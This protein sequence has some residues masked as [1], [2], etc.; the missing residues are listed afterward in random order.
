MKIQRFAMLAVLASSVIALATPA[1]AADSKAAPA[2]LEYNAALA[3]ATKLTDVMPY[4]STAYRQMLESRPKSDQPEWL[5]RLKE[6]MM[7]DVKISGETVS[8]STA[9]LTA[10]G[11]SSMGNAMKG[12][13]S[14]V[15]E[16][17]AWKLDEQGWSK[18]Q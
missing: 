4:L 1:L 12:K 3:K 11:T 16:G 5:K 8:G 17:G 10:T 2:Y 13:I 18:S 15:N 6:S 9:T 14:M 7:K